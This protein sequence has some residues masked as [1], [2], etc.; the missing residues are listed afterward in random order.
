V[1]RFARPLAI[2]GLSVV[3]LA[4]LA[5]LVLG[6][7]RR[8]LPV[9]QAQLDVFDLSVDGAA[10]RTLFSA[11]TITTALRNSLLVVMVAVPVSVVIAS[12]AG[13]AIAVAPPRRRRS[14]VALSL[15]ALMVP[16]TALW[17]PRF[18]LL[19]HLGLADTLWS[20][21]T[22]AL[23]ATTPFYVLVFAYVYW[24]LPASLFEAAL[25]DG[26]SPLQVWRR[27]AWPAG[28]PAVFA[29][30]VLALAAHWSNFSDA[31]LY[32]SS[33][34]R[35]TVP[36]YLRQLQTSEPANFP[37]LLAAS[38]IAAAVP[39]AALLAVERAFFVRSLDL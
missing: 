27:V 11:G 24:R 33:P 30:G 1:R 16:P 19:R 26:L 12:A 10:Y 37:V 39:V 4:P 22:P 36:L 32:I 38:V 25:L 8:P 21:M 5:F 17:V 7:L 20:L 2:A 28:R 13:F 14:L 35:V 29:T 34:A 31:L 6:S 18:F 15:L 3:F 9:A 23:M